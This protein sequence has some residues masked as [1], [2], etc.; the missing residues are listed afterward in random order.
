[1]SPSVRT[2]PEQELATLLHVEE[3]SVETAEADKPSSIISS[4]ITVIEIKAAG[5]IRQALRALVSHQYQLR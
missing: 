5:T 4:P 2:Y 1:M 3:L